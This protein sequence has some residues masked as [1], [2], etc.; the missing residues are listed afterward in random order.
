MVFMNNW[1]KPSGE[2]PKVDANVLNQIPSEKGKQAY[3]TYIN[4]A[5]VAFSAT[6]K[7]ANLLAM[8]ALPLTAFM[9]WLFF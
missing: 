5:D 7:H 3:I 6:Q 1:V 4:R 9:Y 2:G 8:A